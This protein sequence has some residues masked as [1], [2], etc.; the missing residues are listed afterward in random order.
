MALLCED[1]IMCV[2]ARIGGGPRGG[3]RTEDAL[4]GM[5]A[6]LLNHYFHNKI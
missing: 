3:G 2:L 4:L 6:T 5:E 1:R